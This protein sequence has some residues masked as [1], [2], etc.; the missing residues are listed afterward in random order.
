MTIEQLCQRVRNLDRLY[1]G[2]EKA[3]LAGRT[4]LASRLRKRYDA[5][6]ANRKAV[7]G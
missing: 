5:L 7:S 6:V 2:A 1:M 3:M 4:R